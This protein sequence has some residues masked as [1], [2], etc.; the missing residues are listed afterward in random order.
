MYLDRELLTGSPEV[1]ALG[2]ARGILCYLRDEPVDTTSVPPTT[3]T[4]VP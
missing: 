4:P 1:V 2:V 3:D